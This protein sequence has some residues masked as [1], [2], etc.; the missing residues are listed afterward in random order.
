MN[1][2]KIAHTGDLHIRFGSRHEEYATVFERTVKDIQKEQPRR[3]VITGDLFH[4]KISLSPL[5]I[6]L[7][8]KFLSDLSKIA[9]VDIIVGNHD[10]NEQDLNQG[11]TIRV[12]MLGKENYYI[13][14]K[15]TKKIPVPKNGHGVYFYNDSGFYDIDDELVYGV[16]SLWDHEILTLTKKEPG[17]KYV[18]LYHG[19]VYGC[20]SDNGFQLKGDELIKITAFNNFDIVMLGDIHEYQAFERENIIEIDDSELNKYLNDGWELI[21]QQNDESIN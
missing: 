18:A 16:Y 14:D 1:K 6:E 13:I 17:K 2:N 7:A 4:L 10:F 15:N 19:P 8:S 3:I 20:M 5:A 9:P 21:K 12:L 11:N